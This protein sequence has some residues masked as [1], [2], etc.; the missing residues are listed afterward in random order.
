MSLCIKNI[1]SFKG[2]KMWKGEYVMTLNGS[3]SNS[4]KSYVF[5]INVDSVMNFL[6]KKNVKDY[7]II[8]LMKT[9]L[10]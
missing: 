10:F 3:N 8:K 7:K 9:K 4:F 5:A 1:T 6:M 2:K